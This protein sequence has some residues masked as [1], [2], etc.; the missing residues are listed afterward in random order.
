MWKQ[1]SKEHE[2]MGLQRKDLNKPT[3]KE[4]VQ[5]LRT[6][7]EQWEANKADNNQLDLPDIQDQ[8]FELQM[9]QQYEE[10]RLENKQH[11]TNMYEIPPE[12]EWFNIIDEPAFE[13]EHFFEAH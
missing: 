8:D 5:N 4:E 9:E 11:N 3:T 7:C 1:R 6:K 10:E 12:E 2:H 13:E